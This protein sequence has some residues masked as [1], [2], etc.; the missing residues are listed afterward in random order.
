MTCTAP[1]SHAR[2]TGPARDAHGKK[3]TEKR[4]GRGGGGDREERGGGG[5]IERKKGSCM[6]ITLPERKVPDVTLILVL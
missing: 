1:S 6:N 5:V 3:K 4:A 2:Y